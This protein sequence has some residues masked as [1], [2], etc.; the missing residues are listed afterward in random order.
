MRAVRSA[1]AVFALSLA[2][3]LWA[4]G[5][6]AT[7]KA[8]GAEGDDTVVLTLANVNIG[9]PAQLTAFVDEVGRLSGGT[10]RIRISQGW[11][12]GDRLQEQHTVQDVRE[13]KVDMAWV[14]ARV[15]DTLGVKS[16]QA[17]LAPMLVDSYDLEGRVF[18]AGIPE[19]MLADVDRLGV[20]GV[21]ALPGPLRRM[22]GFDRAYRTPADF[23]GQTIGTSDSELARATFE[24]LGAR[25]E[26]LAAQGDVSGLDGVE[27]Q[28][29]SLVGSGYTKAG[30]HITANLEL[31]PRPLVVLMN[32]DAYDSLSPEQQEA[33]REAAARAPAPA[34][35]AS[36]AEDE[37]TL[38]GLC[39]TQASLEEATAEEL[40]QLRAALQP[41]YDQLERDEK[42]NSWLGRITSLKAEVAT[43]AEGVPEC[44]APAQEPAAPAETTNETTAFDGVYR[45]SITR[46]EW[47][48]AV[49][50]DESDV[51]GSLGGLE[52]TMALGQGRFRVTEDPDGWDMSGTYSVDGD[53]LVLH[54]PTTGL[55][56]PSEWELGASLYRGELILTAEAPGGE[57]HEPSYWIDLLPWPR[58]RDARPDDFVIPRVRRLPPDGT[59]RQE[60]TV[61]LGLRDGKG[62]EYATVLARE[63]GGTIVYRDGRWW[64]GGP[65]QVDAS[66]DDPGTY[67]LEDGELRGYW[68]DGSLMF[69]GGWSFA[70]G[71][72]RQTFR[73]QADEIFDF[74]DSRSTKKIG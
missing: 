8:G 56:T 14:G 51:P 36:R 19:E 42:T 9:N 70:D 37:E 40:S 23:A 6:A 15:L 45:V 65:N 11:R 20:V 66:P 68:P 21:A 2:L 49:G 62:D 24:V 44:A 43:A 25:A 60:A 47:I 59:Y 10:V 26:T 58:T 18:N 16:F 50:L 61:A 52:L 69:A 46:D 53:N 55:T 38:P 27:Q 35:E 73:T 12:P 32:P 28:L 67:L 74:W 4:C 13:G 31:W 33:L 41:L 30:S 71:K 48:A 39:R 5:G 17:L 63:T 54:F 3:V 72:L 34:L 7:D 57:R 1:G 29:Q 22:L 64:F